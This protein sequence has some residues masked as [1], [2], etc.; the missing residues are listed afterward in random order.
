[1]VRNMFFKSNFQ[2]WTSGNE[3]IDYFLRETQLSATTKFNYL[4]WIPYS[5]LNVI[6][7][8]GRGGFG[9]VHSAMWIDGPRTKWNTEKKGWERY[10]NVKVAIKKIVDTNVEDFTELF[11]ELKAHLMSNNQIVGRFN[12]LRTYG[13]TYNPETKEYMMVMTLADDGD[14]S[15]YLQKH[16]STLTYIKQIEIL[17]DIAIGLTQIHK[18]GLIHRDLHCRNVMCQGIKDRSQG[19]GE[20]YR[21]VIGD[22][23]HATLPIKDNDANKYSVYY[24]ILHQRS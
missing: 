7:F 13:I 17:Y 5:S 19:R 6:E 14:L 12:V 24:H 3:T 16:F 23:D 21:F 15:D 11:T 22:L 10:S 1:M 20:E 9:E 2:N 4:E 8:I 18:S